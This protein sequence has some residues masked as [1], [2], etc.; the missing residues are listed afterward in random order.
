MPTSDLRASADDLGYVRV[1]AVTPALRVADVAYNTDAT[2][3]AMSRAAESG[4]RLIVFPEL[5][6]TGY[7][8]ADLFYQQALLKEAERGLRRVVA[9]TAELGVGTVV[10][11][12]VHADGR[13]FNCAAVAADGKLV[14]VVPKLRLP[15]TQE[16]YEER[17][18]SSAAARQADTVAVAGQVVPFGND[19]LFAAANM[20]GCV[21]GIEICEDLWAVQPSSGDLALSGATVLVNLS[22]SNEL[23]TKA[24][25]RRELVAQQS[26]RCL[27]AYVYAAAGPGESSTDTVFSGHSMIVENGTTLAE[28]TRFRFDTQHLIADI[29]LD[30]LR[31]ER[32]RNSSFSASTGRPCRR[33]DFALP[34]PPATAPAPGS[35][36]PAPS[37]TPFIP[38]DPSDLA[39]HCHE[40]FT[41]Q[42]TALSR[43]LR[44]ASDGALGIRRP[45]AGPRLTVGISGGLDSTLALLVAVRA[46]DLLGVPREGIVAVTMP[47]PGTTHRTRGNA[48]RLATALGVT[49]RVIPINESV[50]RHFDA[51]GHDPARLDA[52][53]QN[54]Q[55]R[56]RTRILM[57]VAGMS[58]GFNLGTGDLSELALGYCTYNGDHMSMYHVNAGVPKTLVRCIVDWYADTTSDEEI[59]GT[60]RDVCATPSTPELLPPDADG[61]A[62]QRTEAIIGPDELHDFFLFYMLRHGFAP[63]KLLQLADRAFGDTYAPAELLKWMAVFYVAFFNSQFK[64]SAMP[65]GPKVGSVALSPRADWRMPSDAVSTLWLRQTADLLAQVRT[66]RADESAFVTP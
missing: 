60:L 64:R 61:V 54:A 49:L 16:Y 43:R 65:D 20:P 42:A 62:S 58:G 59:A 23:T 34:R 63:A 17:W 47:G 26:S 30:R 31:A 57:D 27:A 10:G 36:R 5:G 56:E 29:D 51:I 50:F 39:D 35:W 66:V 1:A 3:D 28:A 22:A 4:C 21:I 8:C 9:A 37:R 46:F 15:T 40:V 13:L 11:L 19:L 33:V 32:S 18:F 41:I 2:I 53:Y 6:L 7:T 24:R 45:E 14:G 48:E 25:Y 52:T 12:P 55:A 44:H 38:D